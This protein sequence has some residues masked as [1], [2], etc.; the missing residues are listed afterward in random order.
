VPR[1]AGP[2]AALAQIE[3][4]TASLGS[5]MASDALTGSLLRTLA[6]SKRGGRLLELGTGTGLATAWLLDGMDAASSLLSVDDDPAVVAVARRHLGRDPRVHF[7]VTDGGDCLAGLAR[8]GSRF[9]L[10]FADAW[11][12]KYEHL[13]SAL[14]LVAEGGIYVVDDMLP[15]PSWPPDHAPR[16]EALART[17]EDRAD[18]AVTTLGWSTGLIVAVRKTAD[19]VSARK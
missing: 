6:A 8:E 16:A 17:L 19:V 18:L 11:P 15:Q 12:G 9:D 14:G 7:V 2:P 10:V 5:A 1:S 3:R 13:E 4:E